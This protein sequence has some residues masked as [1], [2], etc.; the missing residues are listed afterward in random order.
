MSSCSSDQQT[1]GE[2]DSLQEEEMDTSCELRG[3]ISEFVDNA[4]YSNSSE[5]DDDD[6]ESLSEI[7]DFL[8][9]LDESDKD[10]IA[11]NSFLEESVGSSDMN[12]SDGED[13]GALK[14]PTNI[15][16]DIGKNVEMVDKLVESCFP[17]PLLGV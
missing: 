12:T 5:D 13:S 17:M 1:D 9:Q 4:H 7:E 15:C 10:N 3:P 2:I 14:I 6:V 8:R 16:E 11:K